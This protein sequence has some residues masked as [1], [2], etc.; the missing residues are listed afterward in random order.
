MEW[1]AQANRSKRLDRLAITQDVKKVLR[2]VSNRLPTKPN[3]T[4]HSFRIDFITKLW[5]DSKN[6]EFVKQ[7]IG[8]QN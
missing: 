1:L 5:K 8:H 3:I 4:N 2:E 6:I 7:T